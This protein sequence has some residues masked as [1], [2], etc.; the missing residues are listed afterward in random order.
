MKYFRNRLSLLIPAILAIACAR[1][2]K[3]DHY[4]N[5]AQLKNHHTE[6]V[7][8]KIEKRSAKTPVLVMAIHGCNIEPGTS[9]LADAVAGSDF[10]YYNFCGLKTSNTTADSSD[11]KLNS[12]LHIT[13]TN[14]DEPQLLEMTKS[15]KACLSLHGYQGD[16][17][18]F[19]LGGRD[20]QL[21]KAIL[22]KLKIEF[23]EYSA[24]DLCCPPYL[25][26]AHKNPVNRC[27][28]QGAQIEMGPKVREAIL[29]NEPFKTRLSK[30]LR[31]V[32]ITN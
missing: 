29:K 6:E 11:L 14:F 19:C 28:Y 10:S 9:E 31:S 22:E 1:Q 26:L 8:F 16:K 21:R 13:S 4:K 2:S 27:Q 25:G 12:L 30:V 15:A 18:D 7:D 23:P 32:I 20:D 3:Y 5:F 24:C 17:A